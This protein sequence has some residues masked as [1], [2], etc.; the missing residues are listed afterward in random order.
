M[1]P[2]STRAFEPCNPEFAQVV[3]A[4]FARQPVMGLIGASLTVVEPGY[5]RIELPY[6]VELTQ[7]HGYFHGGITATIADTAAGY[8]AF[9]LFPRAS[10]VLTVE[11]K[12]NL[13]AI[14]DGE[15]LIA[16]GRVRKPGKTLTVV[17]FEVVVEKHGIS[18]TCAYGLGTMM[19]LPE[20]ATRSG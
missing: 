20:T 14:A 13:L 15:R 19:C 9:S 4:S 11:F 3:R 2:Q 18:T 17:E 1:E 5:T 10:V 8:A 16:M 12:I 6:R 7:Q